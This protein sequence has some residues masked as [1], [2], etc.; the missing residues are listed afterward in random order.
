ML[1]TRVERPAFGDAVAVL[2]AAGS[3][4]LGLILAVSSRDPAVALHGGLLA[5]AAM[6]AGLVLLNRSF[7]PE[8]PADSSGYMDGPAKVAT[9]A[10][11]IWGIAGFLV[12]DILAWQLAFPALNLELPWTSFGRLRPLHIRRHPRIRRERAAGDFLLRCAANLSHA[13]RRPLDAMVRG[14]GLPALHRH[15]RHRLSARRDAKQGVCGAGRV[16][17]LAA[18]R[19]LGRLPAGLPRHSGPPQGAAYLRRQ[20][21]LPRIHRHDCDAASR[22]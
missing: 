8:T 17:G 22:Q 21:V 3:A 1:D 15:R 20:L 6:L 13:P 5:A 12:G 16:R 7:V 18:D 19:R 2:A 10:A 4:I 14:V 9:V 11:V